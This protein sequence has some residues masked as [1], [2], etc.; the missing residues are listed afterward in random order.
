MTLNLILKTFYTLE[1]IEKKTTDYYNT[2]CSWILTKDKIIDTFYSTSNYS[3]DTKI[4]KLWTTDFNLENYKRPQKLSYD[5][6]DASNNKKVLGAEK[7]LN[8]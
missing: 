6:I 7:K 1:L 8:M 4:I 2:I 5:L 3:L